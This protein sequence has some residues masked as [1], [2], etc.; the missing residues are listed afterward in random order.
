MRF[1]NLVLAALL[2]LP[3]SRALARTNAVMG[4]AIYI[5]GSTAISSA[6]MPVIA[7]Y[8]S[9]KG[10]TLVAADNISAP[11]K[12][13]LFRRIDTVSNGTSLTITTN[14]INVHFIGSEGGTL[15]TASKAVQPYYPV[16]LTNGVQAG[17]TT[18]GGFVIPDPAATNYA[19]ATITFSDV[20]QSVGRFAV[21]KREANPYRTIALTEWSNGLCA[22][23]FAFVAAT[24]FPATN[25]T[26]VIARELFSVGHCPLSQI[27]GAAA[28]VTNTVYVTGRDIDSGT[29]ALVFAETGFGVL[30]QANQFLYDK[31]TGGIFQTGQGTNLFN[32]VAFSVGNGGYFSGGDLCVAVGQSATNSGVIGT[33][34]ATNAWAP[35][36]TNG[37]RTY[38]VGYAGTKDIIGKGK[39]VALSYNGVAPYSTTAY[40]GFQTS[41][42]VLANGSYSL[43]SVE[44]LYYNPGNTPKG[45][46]L[47]NILD[48]VSTVGSAL[49]AT[50]TQKLGAGY[51]A[52]G[53][54]VVQRTFAEGSVIIQK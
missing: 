25:I 45:T 36:Q 15:V 13:A 14:V 38:L 47:N 17:D 20:N 34:T 53:E 22:V 51:T 23:N 9:N 52:M 12:I 3:C 6:S 2:L 4:D 1:G 30:S 42:N 49:R 39:T 41:Q 44:H 27:T 54:M 28:D 26:A 11:G 19:S 37:G 46:S 7:Q 33:A 32:G 5:A 18:S 24:N 21:G 48:L 16:G 8:A 35:A 31:T 29:R 50:S 40:P 43:W 10:Y